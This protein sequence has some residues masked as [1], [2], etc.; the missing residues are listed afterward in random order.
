MVRSLT[1]EEADMK[2]WDSP[3]FWLML[4]GIV[5]CVFVFVIFSRYGDLLNATTTALIGSLTAGIASFAGALLKFHS[6]FNNK[7]YKLQENVKEDITEIKQKTNESIQQTTKELYENQIEF[8]N[9][10]TDFLIDSL[11]KTEMNILN[12]VR[13]LKSEM[14]E[15]QHETESRLQ[16]LSM[17][18]T[19]LKTNVKKIEE[20]KDRKEFWAKEL[21]K[22]W[23]GCRSKIKLFNNPALYNSA[24]LIKQEFIDFAN[25]VL[26]WN[27]S[28]LSESDK[29]TLIERIVEKFDAV[30]TNIKRQLCTIIDENLIREFISKNSQNEINFKLKIESSFKENIINNVYRNFFNYSSQFLNDTLNTFVICYLKI[31]KP[32]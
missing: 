14:K 1:L 31:N 3:W 8:T 21:E 5:V 22:D 4:A 2:F 27:L 20:N 30:Y 23:E 17:D 13:N 15:G 12:E 10:I 26:S 28:T 11:T 18:V 29:N 32:T 25:E 7:M 24:F 9:K 6:G 19:S 16:Q